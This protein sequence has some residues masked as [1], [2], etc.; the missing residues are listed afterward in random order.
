[1]SA[2]SAK[3]M[4][5]PCIALKASLRTVLAI[6]VT[7]VAISIS[8]CANMNSTNM[9]NTLTTGA[10]IQGKVHGGQSPSAVQRSDYS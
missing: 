2:D 10:A 3:T 4:F 8:G 1:M 5:T 7:A 6:A 9:D